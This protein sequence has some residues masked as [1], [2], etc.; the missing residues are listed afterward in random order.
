MKVS[1]NGEVTIT[2][3]GFKGSACKAAT[4]SLQRALGETVSDTPTEE[5]GET[6]ATVDT[7]NKLR[8]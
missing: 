3:K 7:Q 6:N 1:K 5:M 8:R 4:E 2:T